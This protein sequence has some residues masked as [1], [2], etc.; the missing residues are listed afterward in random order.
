MNFSFW[1]V[2]KSC[3]E[4]VHL[5]KAGGG[6]YVIA[7]FRRGGHEQLRGHGKVESAKGFTRSLGIAGG[8]NGIGAEIQNCLDRIRSA[9]EDRG[10]NVVSGAIAGFRRWSERFALAPNSLE[11]D[12]LWQKFFTGDR[13]YR[14][15]G[16]TTLPPG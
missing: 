14:R 8:H 13:I 4:V 1:A 15:L 3:G 9:F 6:Q 11:S 2:F 5:E 12:F 10:E 16:E 7:E